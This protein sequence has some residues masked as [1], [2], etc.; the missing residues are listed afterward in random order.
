MSRVQ[1]PRGWAALNRTSIDA[2]RAPTHPARRLVACTPR[3]RTLI[4]RLLLPRTSPRLLSRPQPLPDLDFNDALA[5]VAAA[6]AA[7]VA[8][9]RLVTRPHARS[10]RAPRCP[11]PRPLNLLLLTSPKKK[12]SE[13]WSVFPPVQ[14]GVPPSGRFPNYVARPAARCICTCAAA[15]RTWRRAV[16]VTTAHGPPCRHRVLS[17]SAARSESA[18]RRPDH[19]VHRRGRGQPAHRQEDRES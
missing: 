9:R 1:H 2:W 18:G 10:P 8:A 4:A 12:K 3:R 5:A 7:V 17:G 11:R 16:Q 13:T 15:Q 14:T 6:A 19:L